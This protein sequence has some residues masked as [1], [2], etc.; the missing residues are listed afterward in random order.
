[1]LHHAN[2][3][4][5]FAIWQLIN[6]DTYLESDPTLSGT[7][8]ITPGDPIDEDS[9]LT[10][11]HKDTEGTFWTSA[12]VRDTTVF[13]YTYPETAENN[14][15]CAVQYVNR[16]YGPSAGTPANKT[17]A[18]RMMRRNEEH[19]PGVYT[20]WITNIRV[21]ENALDSTFTIYVFLGDFGS[22]PNAW[23]TDKNLVGSHTVFTPFSSST[24]Q[25]DPIVV[26]GTVPLAKDLNDNAKAGGYNTANTTSVEEYLTNNLHWRVAKVCC[27]M[28][29]A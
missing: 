13:G 8:T 1:M 3:D 24:K 14:A 16:L 11:F 28:G 12:A 17:T 19:E 21:A 2:V 5:L 25:D 20:E 22:D 26:A 6:P 23:L 27:Q 7:A 9:P 29:L 15:T 4:R 18:A 10:P